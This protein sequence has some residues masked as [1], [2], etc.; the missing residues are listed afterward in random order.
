VVFHIERSWFNIVISSQ[1]ECVSPLCRVGLLR[2]S[3][4]AGEAGRLDVNEGGKFSI[5][6]LEEEG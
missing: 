2:A 6:K 3:W 1:L 4:E 5:E